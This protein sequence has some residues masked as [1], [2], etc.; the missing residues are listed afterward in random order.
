MNSCDPEWSNNEVLIKPELNTL[1]SPWRKDLF[2]HVFNSPVEFSETY[3]AIL[4]VYT[5]K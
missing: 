2:I 1:K 5:Q 4:N 3:N